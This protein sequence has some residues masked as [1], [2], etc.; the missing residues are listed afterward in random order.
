MVLKMLARRSPISTS[1]ARRPLVPIVSRT[2][3]T[4]ATNKP[5][6]AKK[7]G[8]PPAIDEGFWVSIPTWKRSS[9]NTLRCLIG[10]TTGDFSAMWYL[11]S[12]YPELGTVTTMGL[13]MSAGIM[14][15]I[16]LETTLLRFG[17]DR[18]P[19]NVAARTATGMS[20]ISML[21]ME[22]AEN[23]VDYTL[24]GGCVDLGSPYF[25]TA[26][27]SAAVAGFLVPLPYNYFRLKKYSKSCH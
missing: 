25:W 15:S 7:G 4:T 5:C 23:T 3:A 18:L 22:V 9:V 12:A 20:M 11:Q 2:V 17:R 26:A 14:S 6:H 10:C 13:S 19:W 27:G 8:L 1:L 24:T 16:V 21:A